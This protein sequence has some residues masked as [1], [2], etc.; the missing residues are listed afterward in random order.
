MKHPQAILVTA[1]I[2]ILIS[3]GIVYLYK[4][5]QI[6]D[7]Q[8]II[9]DLQLE[10]DELWEKLEAAGEKTSEEPSD[11]TS[12]LPL[13]DFH[14]DE[15]IGDYYG[16]LY[17]RGFADVQGRPEAFC[18]GDDCPNFDYVSFVLTE[19]ESEAFD[20]YAAASVGNA[21]VNANRIGL[22][23]VESGLISY[24]NSSDELGY[25]DVILSEQDSAAILDATEENP[26]TLKLTRLPLTLGAGAPTCYSHFTEVEVV[27]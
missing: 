2:S 16:T 25:K 1:L 11:E 5:S 7:L 21:F 4:N 8:K 20:D 27:D 24:T 17:V 19:Y 13:S 3:G 12:A 10:N 9:D 18:E 26:V 6:I 14:F 22:G 23:C 15:E